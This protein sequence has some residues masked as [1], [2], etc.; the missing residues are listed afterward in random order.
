M[1]TGKIIFSQITDHLPLHE[2]RR[3]VARYRGHYKVRRFSCLDQYLCMAFARLTYRESLR[4][5]AAF[6][7]I[8]RC[9]CS[10]ARS[11]ASLRCPS[12]P[13]VEPQRHRDTERKSQG[14]FKRRFAPEMARFRSP[15]CVSVSLCL[16]GSAFLSPPQPRR[17]VNSRRRPGPE[18]PR[19][20]QGPCVPDQRP[21]PATPDHRRAERLLDETAI[22]SLDLVTLGDGRHEPRSSSSLRR[23][24]TRPPGLPSIMGR[25]PVGAESSRVTTL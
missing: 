16:C 8:L 22:G 14:R 5:I 23:D 7:H 19:N 21:R 2:F 12:G 17:A 15:L 6:N 25:R 13:I 11:S 18:L 20:R 4:D 9:G 1:N 10:T 24:A 3:C